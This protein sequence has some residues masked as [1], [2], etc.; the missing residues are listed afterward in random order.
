MTD[1]ADVHDEVPAAW[2]ILLALDALLLIGVA[3]V[4]QLLNGEVI[5]PLVVLPVLFGVGLVL[6]VVRPRPGA[7][8]VGVLAVLMTLANLAHLVPDLGHPESFWSFLTSAVAV[9]GSIVGA[10]ALVAVLRRTDGGAAPYLGVVGGVVLIAL[11]AFSAVATSGRAND[12]RQEG[13]QGMFAQDL[14]FKPDAFTASAGEIGIFIGNDDLIRHNFS[15]DELDV[16]VELP[17][18]AFVRIEFEAEAGTYVY[19]CDIEGHEDMRGTLT[20]E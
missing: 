16:D 18:K 9:V 5:P 15:I 20:V 7:I 11:V 8:A 10:V 13:D 4:V 19:Y 6:L 1:P 17:S 12:T 3:V 2:R 14:E